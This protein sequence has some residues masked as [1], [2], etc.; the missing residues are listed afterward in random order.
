MVK[1]INKEEL[2]NSDEWDHTLSYVWKFLNEKPTKEEMIQF[3]RKLKFY[4]GV[5]KFF[6]RIRK[7]NPSVLINFH[8]ISLGMGDIIRNCS[9]S[10]YFS[11][12]HC[13]ELLYDTDTEC[14]IFPKK[15][16]TMDEKIRYIRS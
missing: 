1:K 8:I 2:V 12:I 6:S 16:I 13:I 7:E 14:A 11:S 10:K 5:T 3:G 15:Y 4:N 9:I